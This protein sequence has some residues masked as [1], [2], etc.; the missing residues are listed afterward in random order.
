MEI[1]FDKTTSEVLADLQQQR[2]AASIA[3][4]FE[5]CIDRRMAI[6]ELSKKLGKSETQA[7]LA[8]TEEFLD[9]NI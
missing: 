3:K 9:K 2:M 6:A 5:S 4:L 1:R 7:M 8:K